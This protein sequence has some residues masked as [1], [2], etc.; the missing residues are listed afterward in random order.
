MAVRQFSLINEKGQEF[1]LMDYDNYCFLSSPS[2]LGIEFNIEYEQMGN[3]FIESMKKVRQGKIPGNVYFKN[4]DN[5]LKLGNYVFNSN[6]LKFKYIVPYDSGEK[7]FYRDVNILSL[8]KSE[9]DNKLGVLVSQI[10]FDCLTV[11]YELKSIDY[12]YDD[13]T[14]ALIWDFPWDSYFVDYGNRNIEFINDGQIDSVIELE[15]DG[16][17]ENMNLQLYVEN[18]LYQEIPITIRVE[19]YEKLF[20]S[21]KENEFEISKILTDGTKQNLFTLDNIDFSKDNVMRI[22]P[23]KSCKIV[24]DSTVDIESAKLKIYI[25]HLVV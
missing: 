1:S 21:S 20:Y 15:V 11:W 22:P 19:Q 7:V 2:G 6:S 8:S 9:K 18:E 16:E 3:S 24:L 25:Y 13:S 17:F 5:Y 10:Q 12:S 23:N 4:Y 14:N